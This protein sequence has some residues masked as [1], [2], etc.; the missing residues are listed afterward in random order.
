MEENKEI[1]KE[2]QKTAPVTYT[3]DG[4]SI[5]KILD[6]KNWFQPIENGRQV[7]VGTI[8]A[9]RSTAAAA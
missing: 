4:Q 5:V 8:T 6:K 3:I 2:E 1:E 9:A 7:N